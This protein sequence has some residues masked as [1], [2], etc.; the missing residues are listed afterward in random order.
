MIPFSFRRQLQGLPANERE[1]DDG[2][3]NVSSVLC[4]AATIQLVSLYAGR[5]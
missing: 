1:G 4:P 5:G 2:V 3:Q